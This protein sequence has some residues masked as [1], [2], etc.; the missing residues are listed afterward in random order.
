M[1]KLILILF[2]LFVLP[3]SIAIQGNN[4]NQE[5]FNSKMEISQ[6]RNKVQERVRTQNITGLE[7]AII[8]VRNQEQKQ[9][10]EQVMEKIQTRTKEKLS[11][12]EDLE[13]DVDKEGVSF[14][15][16]KKKAK[17]LYM[18][19]MRHKYRCSIQDDG[20]AIRNNRWTDLFFKD[21][22]ATVCG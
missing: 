5:N 15:E 17:F 2:V 7:N 20:T 12:I 4:N 21:L 14:A 8:R 3:F 13:F 11:Q 6:V 9:H 19:T 10:L 1:K 22:D 16:G 18:F